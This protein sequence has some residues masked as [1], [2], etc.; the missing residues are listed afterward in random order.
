[1][2]KIVATEYNNLS[3]MAITIR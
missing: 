3:T 1:M 2:R